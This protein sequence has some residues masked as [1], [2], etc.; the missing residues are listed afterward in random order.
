MRWLTARKSSP[1]LN[2]I[3]DRVSSSPNARFAFRLFRELTKTDDVSNVFISP[4]SVMLCLTL[5]HELA[6][7]KTREEMAGALEIAGMDVSHLTEEVSR[8]KT[9]FRSRACAELAFANSLWLSKDAEIAEELA[10]SLRGLYESELTTLDFASPDALPTINGWVNART[11]GKISGILD[12]IS[13]LT[14]LVAAN[15]VYFKGIWTTP[16]QRE[17]TRDDKFTSAVRQKKYLPMMLQDGV[18]LYYEDKILQMAALPYEGGVSMYVVLPSGNVE[19]KQFLQ[20][21]TAGSWEYWLGRAGRMQGTIHLPRFKVDYASKLNAALISLGMEQAFDEYRAEFKQV[22]TKLEPVWID[23]V[24]HR[25][26]AEVNEEGTEA[27]AVTATFMRCLAKPEKPPRRF[28]MIV[29]RPFLMVI[30][31]EM[32]KTILF[33]GW[34]GDPQ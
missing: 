1:S 20:T 14:A 4:S 15:A 16:F 13:P 32:T 34:I 26:I 11:R 6:S 21:V 5:V 27:A 12:C 3:P 30:R 2:Q 18:Y 17:F 8:L 28:T 10:T 19:G 24:I 22:R 29:N 9:A 25:A 33:L 31:D 7:G 23:Q